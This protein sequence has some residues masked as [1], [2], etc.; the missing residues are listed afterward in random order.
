MNIKLLTFGIIKE[1]INN[2]SLDF[3]AIKTT[4]DLTRFIENKY[5]KIKDLS[6]QIS[7]NQE[8]ISSNTALNNGDEVAVLPPF[9]GG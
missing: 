2:D 3:E 1:I 7:V 5:P 8:L 4:D 6:Y 9:A